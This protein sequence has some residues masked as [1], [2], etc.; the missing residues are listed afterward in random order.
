MG[1]GRK[2]PRADAQARTFPVKVAIPN[3]DGRLGV[4]MLASVTLPAGESYPAV[5]VPK[6]ALIA[7]GPQ[8]FVYRINGDNLVEMMPVSAG[9]GIGDWIVVESELQPGEKVVTRGNER[10]MPGQEVQG[11]VQEYVLP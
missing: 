5:V 1:V 2:W 3:V 10:L 11:L 9:E 7:Q 6:D 8:R 4:G